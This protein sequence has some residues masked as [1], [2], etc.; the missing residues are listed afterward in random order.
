MGLLIDNLLELS[1]IDLTVNRS[2]R[3]DL[4]G[5]A[6]SVAAELQAAQPDRVVE[7]AIA[8]GLAAHVDA[9]LLRVM[10]ENLFGNA[11]KFSTKSAT[12]EI[13]FGTR[14]IGGQ[15]IYFVRD[16]GVGFDMDCADK[17]FAPFQRLHSREEPRGLKVFRTVTS[18]SSPC[19]PE[20]S[21]ARAIV[22]RNRPV[23]TRPVVAGAGSPTPLL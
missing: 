3:V 15:L 14:E 21:E 17:L 22:L 1:R 11:W 18:P 8:S 10:F 13:E 6:K 5:L 9:G 16:N 7:I 12:P 4:R 2:Q 19:P 23:Q 20:F